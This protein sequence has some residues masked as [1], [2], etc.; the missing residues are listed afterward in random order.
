MAIITSYIPTNDTI[1][2]SIQYY[3]CDLQS[4]LPTGIEGDIAY[5]KNN[6]KMWK[7]TSTLWVEIG[8]GSGDGSNSFAYFIG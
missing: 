5:T 7:R 2:K 4:E 1:R 8:S 3:I 6:N